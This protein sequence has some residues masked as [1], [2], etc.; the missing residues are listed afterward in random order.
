MELLDELRGLGVNVDEGMDRVMGDR[1]LYEMMLG[2]FVDSVRDNP[3]APSDFDGDDLEE[4][5][6]SVHTLKGV[7][8]NLSMIT[9]FNSYAEALG[10]LRAGNAREAKTVYEKHITPVQEKV[11]DCIKR[12][13]GV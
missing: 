7:T 9:L 2:M 3:I 13:R 12:N 1:D 10:M 11:I 8:G 6:K 5:I 4:L